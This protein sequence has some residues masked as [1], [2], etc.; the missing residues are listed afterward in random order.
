V[1]APQSSGC[2]S[3]KCVVLVGSHVFEASFAVT[4]RSPDSMVEGKVGHLEA[5]RGSTC[6]FTAQ[7]TTLDRLLDDSD[8]SAPEEVALEIQ[9]EYST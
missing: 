4:C 7:Q 3:S 8:L 1:S 6:L 5:S 2:S 9:L